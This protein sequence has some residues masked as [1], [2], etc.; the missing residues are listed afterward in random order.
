MPLS[1]PEKAKLERDAKRFIWQPFTQMKDWE[2]DVP[3]IIERG[4]G[5]YLYD[6]H[7]NSYLDGVSSLW[8][9]LFGH[10]KAALD[11]ALRKQLTR[12]AHSTLLGLTNVPAIRLAERLVR[13]APK[14][15]KKVFYSDNGSTA[16][17]VAVKMAVQYWQIRGQPRKTRFLS[18]VNA[19]HGDTLG[20][21]SVGGIDL[22]HQR[23]SALLFPTDKAE[24]PYC[25]RCFLNL[26]FP[27]CGIACLE[28]VEN[29]LK[30]RHKETAAVIIEPLLQGAS[31]M[32]MWP[33][34]Y[35]KGIRSLCDRY[36]V[37][38]IADE[39][40]TGFG[41]TG[42]MFACQHEGVTP[43]LMAVAKGL[44]GG[45][46][47]LA[48]TLVTQEIYNA[49]LG[50]Y[51]EFKTFFHGHSFTGNPLGCSVA[52][53]V[54]EVFEKEAILKTLPRKIAR[55]KTDFAPLAGH[56]H[57]G[58]IRQLGMVVAV[59]LVQNKTARTPYP[60]TDKMGFRVAEE[61]RKRGMLIRP[62]GN[63]V[64]LMPPLSTGDSLLRR[65]T[66]I[67]KDSI[68]AATRN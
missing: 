56:P 14:G 21:V 63:I 30:A 52:L 17:E 59:E 23:F 58:E 22:F 9:N 42:R 29:K 16:V 64:V 38:L 7:G 24:A 67:L 48:A 10:R 57:V 65:M 51:G 8:V 60:L 44:T 2:K 15:L 26:T 66:V 31:G 35:L 49:F 12:I 28:E 18:L 3:I 40:L 4:R 6:I 33:P 19:Y 25:Y 11:S 62:L 61:A 13:I 46:L 32:I 45:Y 27:G 54:L 34:G 37:L 1:G 68:V 47:P 50:E 5:S 43:D 53:A 20:A 55:M 36:G 39:V 41:R